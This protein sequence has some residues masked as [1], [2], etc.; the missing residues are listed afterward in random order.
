[1]PKPMA[2]WG[3]SL[4]VNV[5]R[6][7]SPGHTTCMFPPWKVILISERISLAVNAICGEILIE[8]PVFNSGSPRHYFRT[9]QAA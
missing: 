7:K 3:S 5:D 8:I 4:E 6:N 2:A 1:M 9:F